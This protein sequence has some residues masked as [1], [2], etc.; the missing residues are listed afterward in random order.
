MKK[1]DI[2]ALVNKGQVTACGLV[3]SEKVA[4]MSKKAFYD[5]YVT[6]TGLADGAKDDAPV[7]P[8]VDPTPTEPENPTDEEKKDETETTPDQSETN[9]DK[10][11]EESSGDTP[12]TQ[13]TKS[14]K[15]ATV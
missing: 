1:E 8:S 15:K 5:L 12:S 9:T 14:K 10:N 6:Q 4:D 7:K 11:T 13:K 2:I 3:E